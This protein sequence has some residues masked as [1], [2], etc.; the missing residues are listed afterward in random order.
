MFG[1]IGAFLGSAVSN[2]FSSASSWILPA[3][4][5]GATAIM[6][7]RTP[8]IS[9][10]TPTAS[11]TLTEQSAR[12]STEAAAAERAKR[13]SLLDETTGYTGV[14]LSDTDQDPLRTRG[15]NRLV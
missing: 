3:A 8:S 12:Q 1:S 7:A 9:T 15:S 10:Q 6:A 5:L 2:L 4:A 13:T 14:P 11:A